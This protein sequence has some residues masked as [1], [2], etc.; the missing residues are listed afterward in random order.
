MRTPLQLHLGSSQGLK[1]GW[2][3]IDLVGDGADLSWNLFHPLPFGSFSIDSIFH[4]HLLEHFDF[5]AALRLCEE[6]YRVLKSGGTLRVVVP[7]AEHYVERYRQG[8]LAPAHDPTVARPTALLAA[9][10]IFFRFGHR[11]AYDFETLRLLLSTAGFREVR[12]SSFREGVLGSL[13]DNVHRREGS[14]YCEAVK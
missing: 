8:D 1:P 12:R 6:C 13:T 14:L 9:Q 5:P 7:D 11:S 4:E 10:E 2:V 3:N